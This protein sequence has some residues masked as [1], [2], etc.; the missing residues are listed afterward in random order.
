MI[1]NAVISEIKQ[2]GVELLYGKDFSHPVSIS[3]PNK[4]S[5]EKKDLVLD[6][7]DKFRISKSEWD[8]V[9]ENESKR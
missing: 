9:V 7:L 1:K 4:I 2:M 5:K 3:H 6:L 8:S